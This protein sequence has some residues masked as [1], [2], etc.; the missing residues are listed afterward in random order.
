MLR[1][2][3]IFDIWKRR[4]KYVSKMYM[5]C[6]FICNRQANDRVNISY[7]NRTTEY[8]GFLGSNGGC[9]G[10]AVTAVRMNFIVV[11]FVLMIIGRRLI[12]DKSRQ[13]KVL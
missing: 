11:S 4:Y 1:L 2:Q 6:V 10:F 12:T 8:F 3:S 13:L 7:Q 9:A 5:M